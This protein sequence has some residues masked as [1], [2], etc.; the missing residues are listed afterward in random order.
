MRWK[1]LT[2]DVVVLRE[3]ELEDPVYGEML[4]YKRK[5]CQQREQNS[6]TS[7]PPTYRLKL[8]GSQS[9]DFLHPHPCAM[10][11]L[12]KPTRRYEH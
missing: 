1:S 3:H 11:T 6:I 8:G 4:K 2:L 5:L 9:P 12:I 7:I 10:Q